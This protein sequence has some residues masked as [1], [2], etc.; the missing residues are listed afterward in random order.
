M[1]SDKDVEL[2]TRAEVEGMDDIALQEAIEDEKIKTER[3]NDGGT[4][5]VRLA[6]AHGRPQLTMHSL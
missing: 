1:G 5:E 6:L 3:Q 2:V 4:L